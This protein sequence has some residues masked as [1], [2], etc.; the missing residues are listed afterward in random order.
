MAKTTRTQGTAPNQH[1][2][3]TVLETIQTLT[4]AERSKLFVSLAQHPDNKP[5]KDLLELLSMAKRLLNI[6]KEQGRLRELV[7]R[8][9]GRESLQESVVVAE[10]TLEHLQESVVVAEQALEHLQDE[11]RRVCRY[12]EGPATR[13]RS[14]RLR[15]DT[16]R[17][18]L[19]SD[20]TNPRTI[21]LRLDEQGIK[22][23]L[24]TVLND[25][26]IIRNT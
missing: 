11:H 4:A 9:E 13:S 14:A 3:E 24:K 2:A 16:I 15:R 19:E 18:L 8:T 17:Q 7:A 5:I 6:A 25:L 21:R 23:K 26:S 10:R 1:T 22:V 12:L 20:V